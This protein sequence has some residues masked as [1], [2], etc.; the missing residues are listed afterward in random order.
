MEALP[1]LVLGEV[2]VDGELPFFFCSGEGGVWESRGKEAYPYLVCEICEPGPKG[3]NVG[4]EM[5]DLGLAGSSSRIEQM[6][7][8]VLY[9]WMFA[10]SLS[11]IHFQDELS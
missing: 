2:S 10:S 9:M 8:R 11:D 6:D 1:L 3:R 7:V 4:L 5:L